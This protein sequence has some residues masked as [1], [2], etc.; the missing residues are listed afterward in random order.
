MTYTLV[1]SK[2][3]H[4]RTTYWAFFA[5]LVLLDTVVA[6]VV[7]LGLLGDADAPTLPPAELLP[8]AALRHS[9]SQAIT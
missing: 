2:Y 1:F 8:V 3:C 5:L 9:M 7:A 6:V 4:S